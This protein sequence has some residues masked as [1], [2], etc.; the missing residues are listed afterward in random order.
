M[1]YI[2][3]A[4]LMLVAFVSAANAGQVTCQTMGSFTYC[5]DSSGKQVV[6][7]QIGSFTYCR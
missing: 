1:R 3:V 5:R 6:C 2:L 7:Q 4:V